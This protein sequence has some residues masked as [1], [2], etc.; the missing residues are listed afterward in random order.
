MEKYL[1]CCCSL[2]DMNPDACR[3]C[4]ILIQ[5]QNDNL[6]VH[7]LTVYPSSPTT[8]PIYQE[9]NQIKRIKRITKTVEKF[10][11]NGKYMGKEVITEDHEDVEVPNYEWHTTPN[12]TGDV[13]F[14][15]SYNITSSNS[16]GTVT[17]NTATYKKDVP[18][19]YTVSNTAEHFNNFHK[20]VFS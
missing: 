12:G 9:W 11:K 6:T 7:P 2:P 19:S 20:L 3:S 10:D 18:F 5:H 4:S 8:V 17:A 1:T 13:N 16:L 14:G 15:E